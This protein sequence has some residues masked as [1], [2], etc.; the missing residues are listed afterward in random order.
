V[1]AR[2]EELAAARECLQIITSDRQT[3]ENLHTEQIKNLRLAPI[4]QQTLRVRLSVLE[5]KV[6]MYRERQ[7][8]LDDVQAGPDAYTALYNEAKDAISKAD[9]SLSDAVWAVD[10]GFKPLLRESSDERLSNSEAAS[11]RAVARIDALL[12]GK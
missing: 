6:Q 5:H 4:H 1:I 7:R 2:G 8:R 9:D 12:G 11:E 3:F 10:T